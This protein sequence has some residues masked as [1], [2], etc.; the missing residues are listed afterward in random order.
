MSKTSWFPRPH[1]H[2]GPPQ[3]RDRCGSDKC[4][5]EEGIIPPSPPTRGQS[6][7]GLESLQTM[8]SICLD[9]SSVSPLP[10]RSLFLLFSPSSFCLCF[11]QNPEC[12]LLG[13]ISLGGRRNGRQNSEHTQ[14]AMLSH[15]FPRSS[16]NET[17]CRSSGQRGPAGLEHLPCRCFLLGLFSAQV[18]LPAA[19]SPYPC[20]SCS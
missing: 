17:H 20:T 9:V 15:R 4:S 13:D 1:H 19:A 8:K 18:F 3:G 2:L 11:S 12:Q 6:H 7:C 16:G 5:K 10:F 14:R